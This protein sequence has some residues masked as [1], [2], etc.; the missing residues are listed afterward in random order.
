MLCIF[1]PTYNRKELLGELFQSLLSQTKYDFSWLIVDD[2]STDGTGIIVEGWKKESP[3]EIEY[4]YKENGGKHTAV[5]VALDKVEKYLNV[6][7]DSDDQVV[8]EFVDK[9]LSNHEKYS[10]RYSDTISYVYPW[11]DGSPKYEID[12]EKEPQI[13]NSWRVARDIHKVTEVIRVFKPKVLNNIRFSEFPDEIFQPETVIFS[14]AALKG[15]S[16]YFFYPLVMGKYQQGGLTDQRSKNILLS[17]RGYTLG[18]MLQYHYLTHANHRKKTINQIKIIAE[19][20]AINHAL[21]KGLSNVV[22]ANLFLYMIA[23]PIGVLYSMKK[24]RSEQR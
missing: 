1:T 17:P 11:S 22:S 12:V 4:I 10:K 13:V 5:N 7:I 8:S 20:I 16:L 6:C 3:F 21:K 23:L 14:Q 18:L 15:D 24:Y 2:G 9:I 19:L